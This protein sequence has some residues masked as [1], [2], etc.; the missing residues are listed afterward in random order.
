MK[1]EHKKPVLDITIEIILDKS[2]VPKRDTTVP[3]II[4]GWELRNY[5]REVYSLHPPYLG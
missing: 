5:R 3:G 2:N 1:Y 4:K